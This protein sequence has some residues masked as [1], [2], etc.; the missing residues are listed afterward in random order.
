M[1]KTEE[2]RIKTGLPKEEFMRSES[3][4]NDLLYSIDEAVV[5]VDSSCIVQLW[6]RGAERIW[7]LGKKE[8]IGRDFNSLELGKGRLSGIVRSFHFVL[9]NKKRVSDKEIKIVIGGEEKTVDINYFPVFN[10]KNNFEG[11]LLFVKDV[12][13]KKMGEVKLGESEEALREANIRL[14]ETLKELNLS[15]MQLKKMDTLRSDFLN[16]TSHELKTPLTPMLAQL[17]LLSAGQYGKMTKEQKDSIDMILRNTKRLKYLLDDLLE[18]SKIQSK[19]PS[20]KKTECDINEVIDEAVKSVTSFAWEKKLKVS[21]V[22]DRSI[23]KVSIDKLRIHEVLMNLLS[24]AIKYTDAGEVNV[25]I[26]KSGDHVVVSVRDTGI[27][28]PKKDMANIFLPFFQPEQTAN[29][30]EGTGLGLSISKAIVEVHGG[31]IWFESEEGKGTK[32]SFT[33]PITK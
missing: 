29:K 21:F 25:S 23:P 33:I 27:G 15:Y 9:T 10:D 14:E 18:V 16:M 22:P 31:R 19:R 12:T 3:F 8:A 4:F 7:K 24:N 20:V 30:R 5:A 2:L 13:E 1:A 11:V 17:E 28:I 32:F 6:N 26:K